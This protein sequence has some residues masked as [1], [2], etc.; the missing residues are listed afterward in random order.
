MNDVNGGNYSKQAAKI[1]FRGWEYIRCSVVYIWAAVTI[2][3]NTA[4]IYL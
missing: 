2:L 3:L 4:L 1:S